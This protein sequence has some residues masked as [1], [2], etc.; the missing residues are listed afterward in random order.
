MITKA[1][2]D[3]IITG[4]TASGKSDLAIKYVRWLRDNFDLD[5][6]IINADSAQMYGELKILTA[7]PSENSLKQARH[8]LYGVLSP[9]EASSVGVWLNLAQKTINQLHKKNKIAVVCGGTGFYIEAL[10]YGISN[11][12]EIPHSFR[13]KVLKIFQRLGRD[14]FF[15]Q[16]T[17]LD[18]EL[19]KTLHKNNSQRILRAYEVA[20]YTGIPLSS[21]WKEKNDG[22]KIST[23][24]LLPQRDKLN[25]RCLARIKEMIQNGVVDEVKFF[26]ENNPNY[27]GPLCNVIGYREIVDFLN[28]KT[29]FSECV[30][31]MHL[32]TKSYV[33]KQST[34]FRNRLTAAKIIRKFGEEVNY[35][36]ELSNNG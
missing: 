11:I 22:R 23:I 2:R 29:S 34:W 33:K 28:K 10:L 36:S 3:I 30:E 6:E 26:V 14:E 25:Q 15:Q 18:P 16:L 35:F 20:A 13:E 21:W 8:R 17:V 32:K 7:F 5:A 4:P 24:A 19:C 9:Q 27:D 31:R 1:A 12:P